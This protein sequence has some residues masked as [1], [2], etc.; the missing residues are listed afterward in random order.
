[1]FWKT[2]IAIILTIAV[3]SVSRST[4]LTVMTFLVAMVIVLLAEGMRIVP[5]QNAWVV[6]RLGK[7]HVVLEPGFNGIVPL[8]DPIAYKHS[9]KEVPLDIPPEGCITRDNTHRAQD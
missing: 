4:G 1:M 7:V 8:V 2:I 6:E 9:L 5:Q 3:A